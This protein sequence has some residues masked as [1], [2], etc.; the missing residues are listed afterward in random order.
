VPNKQNFVGDATD[1]RTIRTITPR[2]SV[3]KA[4]KVYERSSC[5]RWFA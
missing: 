1:I 3:A 2:T 5:Y 4:F